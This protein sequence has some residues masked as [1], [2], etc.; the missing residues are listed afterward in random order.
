MSFSPLTLTVLTDTH[1]YS[2]ENGTCGKAYETANSRSQK[3]LADSAEVLQTAFNQIADDKSHDL[4]LI[5]GDLTNNGELNAHKEFIEML[6]QLKNRGKKVFVITATHDFRN[7]GTTEAYSGDEKV[8][9]PTAIRELLFDMY[10][11]FGPDDAIAVHRESMSYIVQIC[12]GY[13]LF[14]LNDDS[15][16]NGKSG[17]S[18]ECFNWISEKAAEA[19]KDN[20]IIIAMTHHPLIAPTPIY[21]IIGKGDMLGDYDKRIEQLADLGIQFMFTGHTHIHN[22]SAYQSTKG[23]VLYDICTCSPIGYPGAYRK[24]FFDPD[25]KKVTVDTEYI[26]TPESF[27]EKGIELK[28]CLEEQLIG[29]IR[30]MIKTAG[31]DIDKLSYMASA[32]SIKPKMIYKFG[33]IIKPVFRFLNSLKIGT[34]AKWTRSETGLKPDDYKEIK[35]RKVVDLIVELVLNLFS[36]ESKYPPETPTYKITVGFLRIIDSI[37]RILH[38]DLKKIIKVSPSVVDL[39]EPILY[40]SKIDAYNAE[41]E[42][43]NNF[44]LENGDFKKLVFP[45]KIQ[46]VKH[47]KKGPAIIFA[48]LCLLIGFLPLWIV[49][50]LFGY[51][52]NQIKFRDYLK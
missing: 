7:N 23:N 50:I 46:T 43:F 48:A 31:E 26:E 52:K 32:I 42:I 30:S 45:D 49:L 10:R 4:V 24:V 39:V 27:K 22:I 33:W 14:A 47:S 15:N 34:V 29:V 19:K 41:L 5:S 2:K 20:Q 3:L 11:E 16:H 28:S 37:L 13:R 36:G 17:F 40:N 9:T 8:Q 51:L 12:E 25:N 6:R 35:D 44:E 1:Y 38:I 21:E 18:D